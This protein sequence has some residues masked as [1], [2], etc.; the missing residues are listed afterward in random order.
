MSNWNQA[1]ATVRAPVNNP[2]VVGPGHCLRV[3][4][5]LTFGLPRKADARVNDRSVEPLQVQALN[6]LFGVHRAEQ[7][8]FAI[9]KPRVEL[10]FLAGHLPHQAKAGEGPSTIDT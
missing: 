2:A 8:L 10:A 9:V 4:H 7:A 6:P 3:V 1:A 5:V